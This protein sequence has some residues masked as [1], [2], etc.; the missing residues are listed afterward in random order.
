MATA[1]APRAG[2]MPPCSDSSPTAQ[3]DAVRSGAINPEAPANA[4]AMGRS[5][6][7]PVLR[8]W[9]GAKLIVGAPRGIPRPQAENAVRMRW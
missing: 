4:S 5:K 6:A 2:R 8:R 1:T 9:A 7:L 3:S